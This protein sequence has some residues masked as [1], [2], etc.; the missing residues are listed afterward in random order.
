MLAATSRAEE[1]T[2]DNCECTLNVALAYTSRLELEW[3]RS[4]G[5]TLCFMI[6]GRDDQGDQKPSGSCEVGTNEGI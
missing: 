6:Q 5:L 3:E 4:L 1:V 2:R